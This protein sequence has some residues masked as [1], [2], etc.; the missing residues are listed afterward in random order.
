MSRALTPKLSL[1]SREWRLPTASQTLQDEFECHIRLKRLRIARQR[2]RSHQVA[3]DHQRIARIIAVRIAFKNRVG[4]EIELS[5]QRLMTLGGNNVM[6][7]LAHSSGVMSRHDG[8][9]RIPAHGVGLER[10][11]IPIALQIVKAEM[12]CL[13]D[14]DLRARKTASSRI[15]NASVDRQR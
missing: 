1:A 10:S 5:H 3:A 15:E 6:N 8:V 2:N 11:S 7:V 9:E 13:P 12:I 4:T 14:F